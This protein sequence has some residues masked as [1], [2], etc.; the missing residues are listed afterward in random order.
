MSMNKLALIPGHKESSQGAVNR[1]SG[2]TEWGF[3][4]ELIM[5]IK[6]RLICL[7]DW[8]APSDIS[9]YKY[10]YQ[11]RIFH[12]TSTITDL[13]KR[14]NA[15]NPDLAI[16]F[17]CNSYKEKWI[18]RLLRF[19]KEATGTEMLLSKFHKPKRLPSEFRVQCAMLADKICG[20]INI[21]YREL[22]YRGR[23]HPK[24]GYFLNKT[25]CRAIIAELFFIDNNSDLAKANENKPAM[26]QTITDWIVNYFKEK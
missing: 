3:N 16:E 12:R 21:E 19:E 5:D 13:V 25:M 10:P 26:V 1:D 20:A 7:P 2:V 18:A 14:I 9:P 11:I 15:W 24:G 6:N 22:K 17:H 4:D 8:D 23:W